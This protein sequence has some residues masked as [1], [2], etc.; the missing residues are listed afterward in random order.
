MILVVSRANLKNN[1]SIVGWKKKDKSTGWS[2]NLLTSMMPGGKKC[3]IVI[4]RG[5]LY[6][7]WDNQHPTLTTNHL[8]WCA[9]AWFETYRVVQTTDNYLGWVLDAHTEAKVTFAQKEIQTNT[10]THMQKQCGLK[11]LNI[12]MI[13]F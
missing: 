2:S 9:I 7:L 4:C 6:I 11:S 3:L 12:R 8:V 13:T 1:E 5:V 10:H